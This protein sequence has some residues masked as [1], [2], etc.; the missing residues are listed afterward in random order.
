[1]VDF[2]VEKL[3]FIL[4]AEKK[5]RERS[6][7]PSLSA[8]GLALL[9]LAPSACARSPNTLFGAQQ[10]HCEEET[11]C[12]VE[13]KH[14]IS[15]VPPRPHLRLRSGR[16]GKKHEA[17][18]NGVTRSVLIADCPPALSLRQGMISTAQFPGV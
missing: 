3:N 17:L 9:F 7:V 16:P 4:E 10:M 12:P 14:R 8:F 18:G 11:I 13:P 15:V 2:L 6:S 1:M 5:K